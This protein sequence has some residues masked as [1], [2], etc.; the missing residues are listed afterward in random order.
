MWRRGDVALER[1]FPLCAQ[2]ERTKIEAKTGLRRVDGLVYG[3]G[4]TPTI[5]GREQF[6]RGA[7]IDKFVVAKSIGLT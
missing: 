6:D 3:N 7:N 1:A 5:T 4:Q 2:P